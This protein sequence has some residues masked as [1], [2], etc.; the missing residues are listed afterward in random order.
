[1]NEHQST[2]VLGLEKN[3]KKSKKSG[4]KWLVFIVILLVA[5]FWFYK[6]QTRLAELAD[7]K[8]FDPNARPTS[9]SVSVA[10]AEQHDMKVFQDALGTVTSRNSVIVKSRIDGQLVN[11]YFREGQMIKTG[12]LIAQIDPRSYQV[13][14]AQANA[15]LNKDKALLENAQIDSERYKTLINQDSISKQQVDTQASLVHQYRAALAVDQAQVDTAKLNLSYAR[16]TAPISGRVGLR[17]VDAGNMIHSADVNGI[18]TITQLQPISVLF[19]IPEDNLPAVNQRIK[20]GEVLPVEAFD[21]G[22]KIK[23]AS[24]NLLTADNQIDATTGT[25]KLRAEF[26]NQDGALFP[27]QFVNVK[28]L[29]NVQKSAV[30]IPVAGLQ[31]GKNGDY[32]YLL[33]GKN[34][35]SLRPVKSGQTDAEFVVI[36]SGLNVGDEV[37]VDGADK[38]SD[39]A[40]VKLAMR[41]SSSFNNAD[42]VKFDVTKHAENIG[43]KPDLH[44]THLGAA[45]ISR[46]LDLSRL[47]ADSDSKAI[48]N[49]KEKAHHKV[50][51]KSKPAVE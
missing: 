25:I 26:K 20:A 51:V 21:R 22:Q 4:L 19:N 40:K 49:I 28:M 27:N 35:V 46:T 36:V 8:K 1:M 38:L 15:Q 13:Q 18:V 9:V 32:V 43:L 12:E 6:Y 11:L 30:V 7:D 45:G 10:K 41:E 34:T 2:L 31:R 37:V 3:N 44:G 29:V 24:G 17:Q 33:H 47:S 23:L 16:I 50:S 48:D 39:G 5:I 14:L 42:N